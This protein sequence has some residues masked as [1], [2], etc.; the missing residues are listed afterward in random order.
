M[1]LQISVSG[2]TLET[3]LTHFISH[4]ESIKPIRDIT[5]SR[6]KKLNLRGV[7]VPE[8]RGLASTKKSEESK[9]SAVSELIKLAISPSLARFDQAKQ[10]QKNIQNTQK[11][12]EKLQQE[13]ESTLESIE[14]L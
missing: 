12:I 5:Y 7:Q 4:S 3:H 1:V 10:V 9:E 13:K 2:Q 8:T 6:I 14:K 11:E